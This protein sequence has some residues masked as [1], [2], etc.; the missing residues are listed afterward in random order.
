[1]SFISPKK[2]PVPECIV[3]PRDCRPV[4]GGVGLRCLFLSSSA[5][6]LP[7]PMTLLM[8]PLIESIVDGG[9]SVESGFL[10]LL[11]ST[12]WVL[13]APP[14]LLMVP[15]ILS[16]FGV[17]DGGRCLVRWNFRG[18]EYGWPTGTKDSAE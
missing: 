9:G 11:S 6:L 14:T 5:G 12:V 10:L 15:L 3:W 18:G 4:S 16:I 17:N 1:M 2:L 7:V 8:V 13:L